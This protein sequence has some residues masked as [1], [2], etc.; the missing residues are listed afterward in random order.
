MTRTSKHSLQSITFVLLSHTSD[1]LDVMCVMSVP[2]VYKVYSSKEMLQQSHYDKLPYDV[3]L[4][5][6]K[7]VGTFNSS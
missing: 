3:Y 5:Y 2:D 6:G 1:I 7:S 4:G